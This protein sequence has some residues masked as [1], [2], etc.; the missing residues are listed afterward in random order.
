M[1]V[2]AAAGRAFHFKAQH[3]T[4]FQLRFLHSFFQSLHQNQLQSPF[5]VTAFRCNPLCG[6]VRRNVSL[7]KIRALVKNTYK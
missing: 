3:A 4:A 2:R 1:E 7:Q 6:K 5:R